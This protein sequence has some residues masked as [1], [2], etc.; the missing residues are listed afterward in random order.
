MNIQAA[1][2]RFIASPLHA[3]RAELYQEIFRSAVSFQELGNRLIRYAE[4]AQA[5]RHVGVIKEVGW[6]LANFPIRD[7]QAIG[8]YYLALCNYK[9][10]IENRE[11]FEHVAE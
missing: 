10:G 2:N 6:V 3:V 11:A 9:Y 4:H 5:I 1:T 8:Q 7:Y